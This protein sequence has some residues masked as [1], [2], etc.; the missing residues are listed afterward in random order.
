MEV[1]GKKVLIIGAARSGIA[2]AKFLAAHGAVVAINDR[3]PIEEWS[4]NA[5]ALK[6][7]GVGCIAGELP[8][9]LLDSVELVVVSPG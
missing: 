2:C 7:D 3:K 9:W 6:N 8:S 5:V 1:A 4:A